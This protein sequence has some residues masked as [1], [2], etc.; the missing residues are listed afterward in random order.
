MLCFS[1]PPNRGVKVWLDQ[2]RPPTL[3]NQNRYG[4]NIYTYWNLYSLLGVFTLPKV[5][6]LLCCYKQ[7]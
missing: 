1:L 4:G 5:P 7:Y 6:E 2:I 3:Q